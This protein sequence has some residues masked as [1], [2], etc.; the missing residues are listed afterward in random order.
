MPTIAKS[1]F[2]LVCSLL[3]GFAL[4]FAFVSYLVKDK[5]FISEPLPSLIFGA[6]F[7]GAG[8]FRP[9]QYGSDPEVITREFT[10][11]VLG[12]QLIL[13][14]I[15]LP[16]KY[17]KME[18]KSLFM[19]LVP[20]MSTMWIVSA[21]IIWLCIP[22]LRYLDALVIASCVTPTDPVLS[23]SLVKGKF[24]EEY[25]SEPLRNIISAESGANDGFGYPFLFLALFIQRD[26]G[27]VVL[28][29]WVIETVIYQILLSCAYG[30]VVGY[31][32]LLVLRFCKERDLVDKDS[33]LFVSFPLAIFIVG[34][35]GLFGTDDLLACFIAGNLFTC[36]W[37]RVETE[38]SHVASVIDMMLNVGVFVWIGAVSPWHEFSTRE[39]PVWRYIVMGIAIL[40]FRRLPVMMLTYKAIPRVADAKEA[41]FIG[42]FGPIGVGAV[43]YLQVSLDTLLT[44]TQDEHV[45]Y[46]QKILPPVIYFLVI[47][48]V[49]VHG[50]AVPIGVY[51]L[52]FPKKIMLSLS[53][54]STL[55]LSRNLTKAASASTP[56]PTRTIPATIED[57]VYGFPSS[58]SR[59]AHRPN[60]ENA[61]EDSSV[62]SVEL[63]ERE[64]A[65]RL[66][67]PKHKSIVD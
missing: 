37:F 58:S 60:T 67:H 46:L 45:L 33:F 59:S 15:E 6:I 13:A 23:N 36:D 63:I 10:R 16:A 32:T 27:A 38:H 3:G 9:E 47:S 43:F 39:V 30:V 52:H 24:S 4:L 5:L 42:F 26:K 19:L 25:I 57:A 29:D 40:L 18:W 21:L 20:V 14:G 53:R 66:S 62:G 35:A 34:T 50:L 61:N 51:G 41:F 7:R 49:V 55:S 1:N 65:W 17:L 28:K 11:V 54:F 12:A 22:N 44:Y 8:L 64:I 2:N 31:V 56:R 48:S